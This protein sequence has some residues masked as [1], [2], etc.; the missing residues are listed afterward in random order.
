MVDNGKDSEME[1]ALRMVLQWITD[2][3][4]KRGPT[5]L[6]LDLRSKEIPDTYSR[7]AIMWLMSDGKVDF[8]ADRHLI[9]SAATMNG[10]V[11]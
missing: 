4:G 11:I 6:I 2:E 3:P 8:D 5:D 1:Y 7:R 10:A 9:L